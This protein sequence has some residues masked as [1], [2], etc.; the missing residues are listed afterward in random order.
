MR[1]ESGLMSVR[2][3]HVHVIKANKAK[4]QSHNHAHSTYGYSCVSLYA[5]NHSFNWRVDEFFHSKQSSVAMSE[6]E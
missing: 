4:I 1:F 3:E 5:I 2:H 6:C